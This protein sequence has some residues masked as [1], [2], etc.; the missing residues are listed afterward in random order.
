MMFKQQIKSIERAG[1]LT[2]TEYNN[3]KKVYKKF[4]K[5]TPYKEYQKKGQ[6][7][8]DEDLANLLGQ[9]DTMAD[10][11]V[12]EARVAAAQ[13]EVP[14]S[15]KVE[16]DDGNMTTY[17]EE[18]FKARL[19]KTKNLFAALEGNKSLQKCLKKVNPELFN[20]VYANFVSIAAYTSMISQHGSII[21]EFFENYEST[22][23]ANEIMKICKERV[24]ENKE[25]VDTAY[26][27]T[28][29]IGEAFLK[30]VFCC[31]AGDADGPTNCIGKI[32]TYSWAVV[33]G[34]VFCTPCAVTCYAEACQSAKLKKGHQAM[35]IE[36]FK[37]LKEHIWKKKKTD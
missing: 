26:A 25:R 29:A 21:K 30:C 6:K 20:K 37:V 19:P 24:D 3:V 36:M 16:L 14:Y 22:T 13:F 2:Y 35:L 4:L 18:Y 11:L 23:G 7:V 9:I 10:S 31:S 17:F 5:T 34:T 33:V 28:E 32:C 27:G 12:I 8:S 15:L 1:D